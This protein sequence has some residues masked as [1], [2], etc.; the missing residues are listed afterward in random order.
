MAA[1]GTL[2]CELRE[3]LGSR[4]SR[5]LRAQGRVIASIQTD[6]EKPHMDISMDEDEFLTSRRK[7]VHLYDL[8]VGGEAHTAVVRELQWDA[9]GDHILHVE[10]KRVTRGVATES[11]VPIRVWGQ[12]KDGVL[13][14]IHST[15][16]ISSIPSKIPDD[17]EM[18]VTG[19][20]T[21][22]HIKASD[23]KLPEGVELALDPETEI[24]VV[25]GQTEESDEV[26][27]IE[28]PTG[29][30]EPEAGEGGDDA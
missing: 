21:G 13:T 30:E 10:F 8:E 25:S 12:V 17:I 28:D 20:E 29:P 9:M 14:L 26:Q 1:S 23:L 4:P 2:Q 18:D 15:V 22:T 5:K 3:Q 19:L 11:E 7:H 6:G 16:T 24:A 27:E